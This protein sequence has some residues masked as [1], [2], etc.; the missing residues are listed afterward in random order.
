[1]DVEALYAILGVGALAL[2]G[3][4]VALTRR[5]TSTDEAARQTNG[6]ASPLAREQ[7]GQ[8]AVGGAGT[9]VLTQI[10]I[11]QN[12]QL[13][14]LRSIHSMHL[15]AAKRDTRDRL[16]QEAVSESL[17]SLELAIVLIEMIH[18]EVKGLPGNIR[19]RID[20]ATGE[21]SRQ[22]NTHRAELRRLTTELQ[23]QS[24]NTKGTDRPPPR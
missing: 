10:L 7:T 15:T 8:H 22:M 16:A 11:G 12:E 17:A 23:R 18:G 20:D 19:A 1:M 21:L 14:L 13:Q 4:I 2:A 3:A 24:A 9:D 5:W 6:Q